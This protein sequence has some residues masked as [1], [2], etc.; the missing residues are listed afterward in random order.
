MY[1][2]PALSL[3]STASKRIANTSIRASRP[4]FSSSAD[5]QIKKQSIEMTASKPYI[6]LYHHQDP[7]LFPPLVPGSIPYIVHN[8]AAAFQALVSLASS[9]EL[10]QKF[11]SIAKLYR[12]S[13]QI[14]PESNEDNDNLYN[15]CIINT[16][17]VGQSDMGFI[18]VFSLFDG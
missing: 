2:R 7:S 12:L 5:N 6:P 8:T 14:Q 13:P 17:I 1:H 3:L 9:E 16:N 4:S 15:G 11:V 18:N 10:R